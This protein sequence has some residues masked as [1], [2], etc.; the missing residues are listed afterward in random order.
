[1]QNLKNQIEEKNIEV[2]ACSPSDYMRIKKD[3]K[4]LPRN[5]IVYPNEYCKAGMMEQANLEDPE[6]KNFIFNFILPK[7]VFILGEGDKEGF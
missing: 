2:Y 4:D 7:R 3:K 5:T 1:M 6:M